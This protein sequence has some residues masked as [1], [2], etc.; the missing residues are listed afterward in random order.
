M[1][2]PDDVYIHPSSVLFNHSPPDYVVYL[3]VVRTNRIWL[4]GLFPLSRPR[5]I[6]LK[7]LIGLTVVNAAWLS[8]LGKSLC[9]FSKPIK[10]KDGRIVVIP[11]FGP[12]G[13]ELPPIEPH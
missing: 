6:D 5:R 11:H 13:W 7:N 3:E 8:N 2:V 10:T 4:K 12:A 1:G 9:T